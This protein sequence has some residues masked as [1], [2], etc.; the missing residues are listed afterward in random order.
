LSG[1]LSG[2][3]RGS[4]RPVT[5][6]RDHQTMEDTPNWPAVDDRYDPYDPRHP[7]WADRFWGEYCARPAAQP[8]PPVPGSEN[9]TG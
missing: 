7:M 2:P 9:P 8:A 5:Q 6:R 1:D 3:E 4:N